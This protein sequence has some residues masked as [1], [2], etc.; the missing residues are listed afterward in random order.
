MSVRDHLEKTAGM[1]EQARQ[2]VQD[3]ERRIDAF[4]ES[5]V[6]SEDMQETQKMKM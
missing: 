5:R 2:K 1:D 4:A 3:L 6:A